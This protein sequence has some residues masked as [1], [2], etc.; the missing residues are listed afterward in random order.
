MIHQFVLIERDAISPEQLEQVFGIV[1]PVSDP[2]AAEDLPPVDVVA[3]YAIRRPAGSPKRLTDL[4]RQF[5]GH[6]L[7]RV[8]AKDPVRG[9]FGQVLY[10]PAPLGVVRMERMT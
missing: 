10:R 2:T 7:V 9:P 1:A 3:G 6:A 5:G 8:E 4:G